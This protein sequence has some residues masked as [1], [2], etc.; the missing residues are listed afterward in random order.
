MN[1]IWFKQE[2]TM[3]LLK[4]T[5]TLCR[6]ATV[7]ALS[8]LI[9]VAANAKDE[10][11]VYTAVE[12]DE[13]AMFEKEFEADYP[14]IDLQWGARDSTGI[15]TAKLLAEKNNPQADIVWGL[16]ATSLVL[17]A[18]EGYFEGYSPKGVDQL[19]SKYIDPSMDSTTVGWTKGLDRFD[20]FQHGRSGKARLAD[21]FVLARS[22]RFCLS[23]S[24]GHAQSKFIWYRI[25]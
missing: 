23:G 3:R 4:N 8:F 6:Y 24:C 11:I 14:D 16:A 10:L 7:V 17:L 19:D 9:A 15:I 25:S 1:L 5:L 20:L 13:L 2:K 22:D 21:A 12:A 18:N